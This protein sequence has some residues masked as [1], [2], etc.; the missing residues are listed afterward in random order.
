ML[1]HGGSKTATDLPAGVS[2]IV[3]ETEANQ[4]GYA[5]TATGAIGTIEKDQTKKAA[6]TNTYNSPLPITGGMGTNVFYQLGGA[7][8]SAAVF[9]LIATKKRKRHTVQ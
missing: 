2:Y 7:V 5:T 3:V 1:K 4:N 9:L 8:I 6:F